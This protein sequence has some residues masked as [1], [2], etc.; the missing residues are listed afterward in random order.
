MMA[1][2]APDVNPKCSWMER[3]CPIDSKNISFLDMGL[4]YIGCFIDN[5]KLW[6]LDEGPCD[7]ALM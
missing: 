5:I 1:N 4:V 3:H 2:M 6:V 7:E